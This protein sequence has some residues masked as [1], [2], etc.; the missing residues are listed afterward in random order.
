VQD[1]SLA[2]LGGVA[3]VVGALVL[4]VSTLLHPLE[5]DPNDAEAAFAEYAAARLWVAGHLGQFLGVCGIGAALVALTHTMPEGRS[6]AWAQVGLAGATASVATSAAL[7]A[8]DGVA[9][10]LMVDRWA[11]AAPAERQLVFEAAF[12]VRQ[13]EIGLASL[14]SLLFGLTAIVYGLAIVQSARYPT[15]LGWIA[16][17]GG[18]GSFVAGI[19]QA[20][21]GFS[22]LAMASSMAASSLLLVWIVLVG[23]FLWRG[24]AAAG[25]ELR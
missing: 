1:A 9:L 20:Y 3:A 21:T 18:L 24:A 2:R 7:Q 13:V 10:K 16:V 12:A 22:G 8:V 4:L 6:R 15:W 5:T 11:A 19:A 25:T 23:V 14:I 17:L